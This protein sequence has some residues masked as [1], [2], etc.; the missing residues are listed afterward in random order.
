MYKLIACDIDGTIIRTNFQ[1]S[2][3]TK[4]II[5]SV[6]EKGIHFIFATGRIFGS[7]RIY[8]KQLALDTPIIACNG[9][10]V[11]HSTN[12]EYIFGTP[13][14][15][16]TCTNVFDTL[17]E[18]GLYF[19]YYGADSFY[20]QKFEKDALYFQRWNESLPPEDRIP[21]VE[22]PDPYKTIGKDPIYKILFHC[23]GEKRKYYF[24]LFSKIPDITLTSS[25]SNNFEI[26]DKDVTK[27]NAVKQYSEGMNIKREEIICIGDNLNDLS[28]IEFAGM[29]VVM[30]NATDEV[31]KR[32]NYVT[33]SN[34][35]DGAA[36]AIEKLIF[37]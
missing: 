29:G 9:A 34:D 30:G 11:R 4:E 10:I 2:S 24:D 22:T 12:G 13:I 21:I 35:M 17:K 28:M 18:E 31:K 32:G 23:E 26:C 25:W 19:H 33:D 27:G 1:I 6:I 7:A 37:G 20:V 15:K 3:Y 16:E 36:R 14:E 8:A 5:Q